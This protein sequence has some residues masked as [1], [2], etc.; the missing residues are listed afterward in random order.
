MKRDPE[1][2]REWQAR[3]R[4][5]QI[6]RLEDRLTQSLSS[7]LTPDQRELLGLRRRASHKNRSGGTQSN[8]RAAV[9]E[10]RGGYC[11]AMFTAGTPCGGRL[12][13]D[14]VVERSQGGHWVIQNGTPLCQKHH[15]DKTTGKL[16]VAYEWLDQDQILW[17][18][19]K[20][21][22]AWDEQGRPYGRMCKGFEA[23][24]ASSDGS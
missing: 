5:E 4:G 18:A 3:S 10:L 19:E 16:K 6:K 9:I 2:I 8:W 7:H 11:R 1:K 14:H 23:R 21:H 24:R 12:E 15:R 22:V 20:G 13:V 17:L